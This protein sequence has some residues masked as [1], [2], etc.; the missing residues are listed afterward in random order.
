MQDRTGSLFGSQPGASSHQRPPGP[1]ESQQKEKAP[2]VLVAMNC[3]GAWKPKPQQIAFVLDIDWE[4]AIFHYLLQQFCQFLHNL[5][6]Q[7]QREKNLWERE[8]NTECK[9]YVQFATALWFFKFQY[10]TV[11]GMKLLVHSPP[12]IGNY[13]LEK[14]ILFLVYVYFFKIIH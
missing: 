5:N 10:L 1:T 9:Q 13:W 4:R 12:P 8:I 3:S 6:H 11:S 14:K 7:Q 2:W